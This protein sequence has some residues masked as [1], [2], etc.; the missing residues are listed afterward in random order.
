MSKTLTLIGAGWAS[1]QAS[2]KY[3]RRADSIQRIRSLLARRDLPTSVA[4]QANRLLGELLI[5]SENYA[6]AR[7]HLRAAAGF[8]PTDAQTFFQW[9]LAYE[10]DPHGSDRHAAMRFRQA[11][12][13]EPGNAA[14]RA[15]FGRALVRSD[16]LKQGVRVL[17][18][19]A[20]TASGNSDVIRVA[21]EGLM[22][23]GQLDTAQRVLNKAR[24]QCFESVKDR[25]LEELQSRVRFEAARCEQRGT[26]RHGQ[27]AEFARDGGRVVLPFVRIASETGKTG[28]GHSGTCRGD[29]ISMPRPHLGRLRACRAD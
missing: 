8:A 10:Q 29:V 16:R 11:S 2:A 23:A 14:Y 5:A 28:S 22:E 12:E 9:G 27:D 7:R 26:T 13:L 20:Q 25:Q 3:G 24:F 6:A 17:L 4:S 21:V 1:V 15:A 18:E 19:A